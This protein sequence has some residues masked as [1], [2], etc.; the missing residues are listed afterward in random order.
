VAL[1]AI[2]M[3]LLALRNNDGNFA[4]ECIVLEHPEW[5]RGVIGILASRVVDRTQRPALVMTTEDGQ[6]HGSGRSIAGYHLLDAL[7]EAHGSSDI[8]N[9]L[10][11]RFGG[12]A[13]AVGFSLPVE[14]LDLLRERIHSHSSARLT[15]QMLLPRILCDL[16]LA[17]EELCLDLLRWIERCAPFGLGNPEPVFVTRAV[18][19]SDPPRIIKDRHVCLPLTTCADGKPISAIGWSRTGQRSW[20]ERIATKNLTAGSIIDIVYRLRENLHPTFGRL[21]LE[22]M[23]LAESDPRTVSRS[24]PASD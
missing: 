16:E 15:K 13:F 11:T 4:P 21:E 12:H 1:E 6:A 9:P 23:D 18:T 20:A 17:A 14:R 5:H 19:L 7:T 22:L 10:F 8:A 3:Q 24:P 2:E